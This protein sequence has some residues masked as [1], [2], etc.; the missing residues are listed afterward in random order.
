MVPENE[1]DFAFYLC[2]SCAEKYG[3]L[4]GVEM[5]PDEV[6]FARIRDAQL[7]EHGRELSVPELVRELDDLDS[8]MSK[9]ARDRAAFFQGVR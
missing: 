8:P 3:Q 7:E 2:E 9:L 4:D 5:I 1:C 6:W